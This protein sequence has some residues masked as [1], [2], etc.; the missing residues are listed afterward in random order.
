M[1]LN[2]EREQTLNQLLTELDGYDGREGV[3]M[4][5]A[6]NRCEEMCYIK[7]ALLVLLLEKTVK[8]AF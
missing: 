7:C 3:L 5:A 8:S 6:T 1:G 4:L 2:E